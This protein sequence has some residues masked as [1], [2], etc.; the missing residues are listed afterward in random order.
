[1]RTSRHPSAPAAA[2]SFDAVY[3]EAASL[4]EVYGTIVERVVDAALAA[5]V[6]YAVPGSPLVAER[7]VE[8]LRADGRVSVE[9]VAGLSFVDLA[10]ARLGVDPFAAGVRLVDGQRFAVEAAGERGPFLVAQCDSSSVLSEI[11]LVLDEA[12]A[13]E[14]TVLAQLGLPGESVR[15]VSA[16][17]L[18][19]TV[20]PDHLTALWVAR[21]GAPVA[22]SLVRLEELVRT[23]RERCPWDRKQ[24][25]RSLVG[26]LLEEAYEVAET[27]EELPPGAGRL[28]EERTTAV[29]GELAADPGYAHLEEELGDLLFQ[30][31]FHAA[32]A[33]EAGR[34]NL[35][36]VAEGIHTKL[37]R[38]HPHVFGDVDATT[39]GQVLAN[40]EKL[41][42]AEKG[43]GDPAA[44]VLGDIPGSLPA[45]LYAA[46]AQRRAAAV[47][48]DWP[49]AGEGLAKLT[50]EGGKLAAEAEAAGPD[51][52]EEVGDLLFTAVSVAR[53]LGAD[54][55][56]A[57]RH[58][59]VRFR[60]RVDA[61]AALAA[62]RGQTLEALEA[63]ALDDLW[64]EVRTSGR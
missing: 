61:A 49:D 58:A 3:D 60:R 14:V 22:H 26:H 29:P 7:T 40:W 35:A 52:F 31:F 5:T 34:F 17:D 59:V 37:V 2:A 45:L 11:K 12:G 6:T 46:K 47:G 10:W 44:G 38:R 41:K 20:E 16:A 53:H 24:D 28:E 30:V 57:L 8:L 54:P 15:T 21:L 23:L 43:P 51:A 39:A 9:L 25:H 27:I 33:T 50:E 56:A 48:I 32:L 1:V 18:D 64:E 13:G 62:E 36:D 4:E 55:E 42:R 19:R 63:H